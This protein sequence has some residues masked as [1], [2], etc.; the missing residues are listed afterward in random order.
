MKFHNKMK[1]KIDGMENF[2][3]YKERITRVDFSLIYLKILETIPNYF[4]TKFNF[5]KII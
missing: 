3:K 2:P 4:L 5:R 1:L